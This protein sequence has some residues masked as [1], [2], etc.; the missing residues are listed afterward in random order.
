MVQKELNELNDKLKEAACK[1][2]VGEVQ[3][4]L[5]QGVHPDGEYGLPLILAAY[6]GQ[7][8]VV[9]ILLEAGASADFSDKDGTAADNA[10]L[11]GHSAIADVIENYKP[12]ETVDEVVFR[13][14]FGKSILEEAFNFTTLERISVIR[15]NKFSPADAMTITGFSMIEDKSDESLL[16]KAF[17]EH[18]RRGG[19]TDEAIV[20]P[21]RLAKNKLTRKD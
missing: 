2:N 16:R 11:K 3:S 19:R 18:R 8:G 14:P 5:A 7:M 15:K 4:L 12:A 20:F 21:N 6:N 9:K 10:R 13:R 17:N 1:G